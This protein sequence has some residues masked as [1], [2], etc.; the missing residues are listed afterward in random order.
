MARIYSNL[1]ELLQLRSHRSSL[2]QITALL[3][4]SAIITLLILSHGLRRLFSILS[5][6]DFNLIIKIIATILL[7]LIPVAGIYSLFT[8]F[9]FW[10]GWLQGL[11]DAN[12]IFKADL[13]E[14][15][16]A[17]NKQVSNSYL[18]YL[19]GIHQT[20]KDHPPRVSDFLD[21]LQL[22][23]PKNVFLLRGLDS[24]TVMPT[25]LVDDAGSAWI[26]RN[27]FQF[28]EHH[29]N[30][31]VRFICAFLVQAN[32]IIKVG[33]SSDRRYGPILN[34]ELSLKIA[35]RLTEVG[36]KRGN[37][38]ILFGYSGGAEMAMGVADYLRRICSSPLQIITCCGVFSGNQ[39]IDQVNSIYTLIGTRDPVAAFGQIAYLGRSPLLP[40][41]NWNK[42]ST[43]GI[44]KRVEIKGMSH[45]GKTGPFS[46]L[47]K[48]QVVNS[49][50]TC[51]GNEAVEAQEKD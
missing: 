6:A 37:E 23:L 18:V 39:I 49:I 2:K 34:Y 7:L 12:S 41:S 47:Y 25:S 50:I 42:E 28:Q 4:I 40:L 11:P 1:P 20:E 30:W 31:L 22:N 15:K 21:D 29:N 13:F 24:Y 19:D 32:N 3:I 14:S 48:H 9:A 16:K 27:L 38:I 17:S 35:M 8:Q 36:Y 43:R 5:I 46:K 51:L 10:E 45:N 44:I 33:I 26:W